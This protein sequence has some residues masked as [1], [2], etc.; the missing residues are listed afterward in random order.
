M[1]VPYQE[2]QPSINKPDVR[3][4]L[5]DDKYNLYYTKYCSEYYIC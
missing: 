2:I 5:R 1:E 4:E 3:F